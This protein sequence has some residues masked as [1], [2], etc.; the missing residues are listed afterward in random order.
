MTTL[1]SDNLNDKLN[2]LVTKCF[3]GNRIMDR[4]LSV[5]NVKFVMNKTESILHPKMAHLFP[6]LADKVSGYQESRNC[7][8]IYGA[9]P[10]DASDYSAPYDFFSRVLDY[11]L[12]LESAI[13]EVIELSKEEEDYITYS[14]L[15]TF[16]SDI[17]KVTKQALLLVD[18]SEMYGADLKA[19]DHNIEDFVIL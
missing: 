10:L 9:T 13:G 12:D 18:K 2:L 3:E 6:L 16:A 1:I 4:G 19:F 8:T 15:L 7:L 17:T 5:L 11:M 14:F